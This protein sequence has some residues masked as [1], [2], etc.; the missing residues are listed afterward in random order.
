ME[1]PLCQIALS[2]KDRAR[3]RAW[4]QAL[5]LEMTGTMGPIV[6]DVPAKMLR[7]PEIEVNIDW[8]AGRDP[9]S[10][11]ELI[12]FSRPAPRPVPADWSL[13]REGYGLVSLVVPDFEKAV[14]TLSAAN[15]QHAITGSRG[16]RSL[17]VKDPDGI[18]IEILEKDPLGSPPAAKGSEGLASIRAVTETVGD[19]NKAR[20]F[21]TAA[22][23]LTAH[24]RSHYSFNEFPSSLTGG[25]SDWEGEVMQGGTQLVRLL[26]PRGAAIV[27][28]P[29]DYRLSD[30]GVLNVAGIVA[31]AAQF[32]TLRERVS[33]LGYPFSTDEPMLIGDDAAAIYG[34]DDQGH[35]IELG[36]VLPGH[37]A[38]YGWRR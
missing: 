7:V 18:S 2:V 1:T 10:Q 17:W 12:E 11:L 32:K 3:S 35:S 4:Y 29:A 38:V 26:K 15:A 30:A 37:E 34:Y 22:I 19:L 24:S 23:G 9:M 14:R 13:R 25:V 16:S 28:R 21:W 20:R 27:P 5:G 36:F 6:G 33:S 31:S 8:V